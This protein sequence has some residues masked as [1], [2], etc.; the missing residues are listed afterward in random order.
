[1]A[2]KTKLKSGNFRI[3][4][5]AKGLKSISRTFVNE[6][7]A[8]QYQQ[9]IE[10]ELNSIQSV[11]QS[12]LPI[13][14]GALY[15]TLHPDVKKQVQ[16]LPVFARVL[17]DIAGGEMTLAQLIDKFVYQYGKKDQNMLNR[18]KW[19]GCH[20]GHL[21][22][23]EMTED[24]VRHGINKLLTGGVT[25]KR[26]SSPQTTNRFKANLSSIFEFGKNKFHLKCNPCS[27]IKSKPEGKGR[28]RY[29]TVEEQQRL[30]A[31][32]KLSKW[33]KFY[34][35][36]LMAITSGAR[37]GE[38]LDKLRWS[39][40][41]WDK[42]QAVCRDTKNGSNKT[43][44]LTDGVMRELKKYREVGNGLVFAN[45]KRPSS[46]YDFRHEWTVAL[47]QAG[48]DTVDERGEKLVFHSLRHTFCSTIANSGAELHEIAALAGHKSIQ[49]T[50][51][52]THVNHK[53]LAGVIKSTF[54][55]II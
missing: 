39:D 47:E 8:D 12:K 6:T 43:L 36:I 42:S 49:T 18:L 31:A 48:I 14:M 38:L 19:W 33:N 28:Q 22:V 51:R 40:V 7:E 5:R 30:L 4:F 35:L 44:S 1:M 52:Y 23:S 53:K 34:L 2:T 26:G 24:Y 41:D 13:D 25:G 55:N 29:L 11:T 32:A 15:S 9:R 27:Q 21:K 54:V 17:G 10:S 37:R 45:H 3:Q 16:L 46:S 20:Y 50:M